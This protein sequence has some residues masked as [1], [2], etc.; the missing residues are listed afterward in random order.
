MPLSIISREDKNILTYSGPGSIRETAPVFS[1]FRRIFL[2]H[3]SHGFEPCGAAAYFK[4]LDAS[5]ADKTVIHYFPYSGKALPIE[6]VQTVY[7]NVRE[8]SGGDLIL[9]VG[10]GTVID[11]AKIISIAYSNSCE[12]VEEVITDRELDNYI[13]L[14]YIPTTAGT[15]SETTT[16][17]VVYKDKVKHSIDNPSLLPDYIVL[18]PNLLKSL[19]GQLLNATVLDALAQAVESTWAVGAIDV[20]REFSGEAIEL[21][22]ANLDQDNPQK[23]LSGFQVASHLAGKAINISRTTLSH[24]ISYPITAYFDVPHGV[25]VFL[26]LP[27]VT[28]LNFNARPEQLQPGIKPSHI[29]KSFEMLLESFKVETI[30]ELVGSMYEVMDKLGFSRRLRDYGIAEADLP[31]LAENAL[32]KGRSDNNPRKVTKAEILEILKKIF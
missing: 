1:K 21:I 3:D 17:A 10:G 23:R 25:A 30:E 24:S 29:G 6:D 31:L 12:T 2:F 4:E 32:N 19:P 15:G 16:F 18:D 28:K 11:L 13:D 7:E 22:M 26:T 20:S 5:I 14:C 8:I 27:E 9:A